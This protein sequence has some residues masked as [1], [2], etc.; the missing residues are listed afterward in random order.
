VT[1]RRHNSVA[2]RA[3]RA[4]RSLAARLRRL[5][6]YRLVIPLKRSHHAPEYTARGVMVGVVVGLTPTVGIQMAIAFVVWLIARRLFRWDFNVVLAAA[7]TW[8]SNVLTMVPMYYVFYLTGQALLGHW[9]DMWGY[10]TFVGEFRAAL[11]PMAVPDDPFDYMA[12]PTTGGTLAALAAYFVKDLFLVML[13]GSLPFWPVGGWLAYRWSLRFTR[14]HHVARERRRAQRRAHRAA[15][16][17]G[18]APHP[19][20]G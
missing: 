7:W 3:R 12:Y 11:H 13:L 16:A 9:S 4:K 5:V 8:I 1:G 18:R 2:V 10:H 14:R 19:H 15:R 6:H 17:A 20:S